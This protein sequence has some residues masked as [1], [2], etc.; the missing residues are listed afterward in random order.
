VILR[1]GEVY[2][3]RL[4]PT[5]GHEQQGQARPCLIV[6]R[7]SLKNAG[8]AIVVPLTTK[9]PRAV[10]PLSVHLSAG[11]GGLTKEN[12]AKITQIRVVAETRF[13][14]S[15]LAKLSELEMQQV[16]EALRLVLDLW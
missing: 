2:R 7:D 9:K 6:H 4:N 10:F 1:R 3:V 5:E 13:L 8:T 11:T 14:K 12:W 16:K 15:P